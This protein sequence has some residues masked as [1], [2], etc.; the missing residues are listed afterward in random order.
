MRIKEKFGEFRVRRKEAKRIKRESSF[1]VGEL[2]KSVWKLNADRKALEAQKR[3]QEK[4]KFRAKTVSE[5]NFWG[6]KI[7]ETD[8]KLAV[9]NKELVQVKSIIGNTKE[10]R[11]EWL[12]KVKRE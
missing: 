12:A 7:K 1:I 11:D 9:I 3:E 8:F 6:E 10:V 4:E 5:R 2:K